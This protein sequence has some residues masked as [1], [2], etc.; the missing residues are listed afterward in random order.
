MTM[1]VESEKKVF[2]ISNPNEEFKDYW[3]NQLELFVT[4]NAPSILSNYLIETASDYKIDKELEDA[5]ENAGKKLKAVS[6][7]VR[8]GQREEEKK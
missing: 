8:K 7:S 3:R 4:T 2:E 6:K 1:L 5:I